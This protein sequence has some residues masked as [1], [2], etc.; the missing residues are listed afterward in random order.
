MGKYVIR[1]TLGNPNGPIYE[2]HTISFPIEY[3]DYGRM[4]KELKST[5][6]GAPN[7]QDCLIKDID[8]YYEV[9]DCLKGKVVNVDELDYLAKRLDSFCEGEDVQFQG[10][11][12]KLG[13]SDIKDFINLTFCCQ[14]ATVITDFS[15]LE[16]IGKEHRL[17]CN[18]GCMPTEQ[19]EKINGKM[20]ALKLLRNERGTITPYGVV[21]DNGMELKPL[22]DGKHLPGYLYDAVPA[23]IAISVEGREAE[24]EM[25]YLPYRK[26]HLERALERLG[27]SDVK[28]CIV[29]LKVFHTKY[30]APMIETMFTELFDIKEHLD[31]LNR[32]AK[33]A[34]KAD[35]GYSE[36]FRVIVE[37]AQPQTPE[38]V[39]ALAEETEM[40]EAVAGIKNA[41]GYGHYLIEESGHFEY[42]SN[43][44]DYLDFKKCGEKHMREDRGVITE[45]GYLAY[46]GTE[47]AV[48]AI[49]ER[50]SVQMQEDTQDMTIGGIR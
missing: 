46:Q 38:E 21:Y 20:E 34:K 11:S 23:V 4:M 6:I 25:L 7:R 13:I 40:F 22:Y 8:S 5:G 37:Y 1:A 12:D 15:D 47:P 10:M 45:W 41:E 27:V 44:D 3:E 28:D 48:K 43:L 16:K 31:T 26:S 32:L 24:T 39:L 42:D 2:H 17:T 50:R 30:I 19:Y 33:C 49:M 14:Q 35:N 29:G 18:G 9:L 36:A